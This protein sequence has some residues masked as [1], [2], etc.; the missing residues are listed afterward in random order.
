VRTVTPHAGPAA[1][2]ADLPALRR[3]VERL[4][5]ALVRTIAERMR[6]ARAIGA[7]KRAAGAATLDPVREAEVVRRA[8]ALAREADLPEEPIRMVFWQLIDLARRLQAAER[9]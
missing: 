9:P 1:A 5:R 2:P 6:V 8:G 4:D 7:A 3:E